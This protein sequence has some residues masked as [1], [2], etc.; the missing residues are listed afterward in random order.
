MPVMAEIVKEFRFEAA[1]FLPKVDCNH[2]CR[3]MHGHGFKLRVKVYG[4]VDR[5]MGW[6]M[7]YYDLKMAV[8]PLI[9]RMDHKILN[10]IE[11]LENPTCE[12]LAIW[13]LERIKA[14][15]PLVRSLTI[16]S[17]DSSEVTVMNDSHC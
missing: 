15:V 5:E 1:H 13:L 3:N 4:P 10:D 2:K 12:N 9:E 16:W 17:T 8:E 14:K 6:V 11:G 7:D